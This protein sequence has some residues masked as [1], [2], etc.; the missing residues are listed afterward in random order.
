MDPDAA[1]DEIIRRLCPA[2]EVVRH[3]VRRH[4]A[5]RPS[6]ASEGT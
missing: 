1:I 3:R 4:I 6:G 2:G 5:D